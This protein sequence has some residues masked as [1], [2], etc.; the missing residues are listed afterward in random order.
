[1]QSA[2]L[3]RVN[4][5]RT[6]AGL[7]PVAAEPRLLHAAQSHTSYLESTDTT[8]HYETVKTDPYYTGHSPF[9]R[10]DAAHYKYEEAGEVVAL[11]PSTH[12]PAA[13][14]ALVTAIYHR[15]IILLSDVVQAGPGV[16]LNARGG[17]EELRVTVDFGAETLPS[18]PPSADLTIYPVDGHKNVRVDF[19]PSE[20]EPNPMP[21]HTLVGYPISV[22]VD[23]RHT[24]EVES[25]KLSRVN[26]GGSASALDTLLLQHAVNA[27][28][29]AHA[30]AL[31]P[32]SPLAHGATYRV[33][34]AGSVSGAKISKTWQF[35]TAPDIPVTM[36][37]GSPAVQPGGTQTV[38]LEGLDSD[39]GSYHVCYGPAQLVTSLK[40]ET[41]S[42]LTMT[43]GPACEGGTTCEVHLVA[44]YHSACATPFAQGS[45][46]IS[47]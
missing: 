6:L 26:P 11:Q 46:T 31:I 23:P 39:K 36:S 2:V 15:F 12:P 19:D 14:D 10:I 21:G 32:V 38:T 9:D 22:Q 47:R 28:T 34:F 45:F 25:F 41:Q 17:A 24:L 3:E 20:E 29:P 33:S 13:V 40:Y 4:Y 18:A 5:H 30:A 43:I 35:T 42:Q 37:F 1:M 44:S 16:T 27:E 7:A 8:G